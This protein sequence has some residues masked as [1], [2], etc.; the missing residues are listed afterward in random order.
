MSR[1]NSDLIIHRKRGGVSADGNG[2]AGARGGVG[3][4]EIDLSLIIAICL[5]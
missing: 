1:N 3:N 2:I 5:N 4:D